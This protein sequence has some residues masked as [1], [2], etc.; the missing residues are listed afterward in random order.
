MALNVHIV[1]CSILEKRK[2]CIKC[3]A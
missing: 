3:I 1:D 2:Q